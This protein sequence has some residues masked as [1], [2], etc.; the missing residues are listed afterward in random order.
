MTPNLSYPFFHQRESLEKF[1]QQTHSL[2]NCTIQQIDFH[3]HTLVWDDIIIENTTFL[4]CTFRV[5]DRSRLLDRG[6]IIFPRVTHLPYQPYRSSLYSWQELMEGY[7]P[8][9]DQSNDLAIYQY[10]SQYK[11]NPPVNE[12]LYQRIHDHAIDH[13][14]RNFLQYQ[15]DGLTQQRCVGFMGGH[16]TLRTDH[17]YTKVAQTARLIAEDGYTVVSGGGPGIM[18]AA[19]LGAYFAHQPEAALQEAITILSEAP[20][21]Q[22]YGFIT[23]AQQVLEKFP[24]GHISLAI[25][26]WF[27]GHEPSNLFATHIAKYFSNSIRED[28]L[29]AICLYGVVFAPGSAGTVQEIFMDAAQNH[30]GSFN[31]YSP[32]IFLGE[33]WYDIESMIYPLVRKLSYG[34]EYHDLLFLSDDPKRIAQFIENHQPVPNVIHPS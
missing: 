25:P 33:E 22:D 20:H 18:E 16:S 8:D 4:G 6:A 14:L 13:A 7:H 24:E 32:M 17:Y 2:K 10:F 21:Y 11:F 29:L 3:D 5:E 1:I 27:Y 28:T 19:N 9:H 31:Y 30:Y 23:Q 34:K 12:A 15:P 26:T